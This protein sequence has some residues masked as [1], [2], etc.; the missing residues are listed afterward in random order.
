M[1]QRHPGAGKGDT[2]AN[3]A[4]ELRPNSANSTADRALDVLL[5]F[6]DD[7]PIWSAADL[8]ERLKMPRSTLYRYLNS[9]R[10]YNLIVEDQNGRYRLGP[11]VL[12]LARIAR[13]NTSV[14]QIA[15]PH[16]QRLEAQFGEIVVL[17]ERMGWDIVNLE[18]LPGRH[19]ITLT[20]SRSQ[21]LPWPAAPSA[22][23]FAAFA[24][25]T[26][27]KE[28]QG[29]MRPVA[30]TA[31]TTP[32]L[33]QLKLQLANIRDRGYAVGLEELD[34]GVSGIAVP[35][36]QERRC[37]YSLSLAAPSFRLPGTMLPDVAAVFLTAA[38]VITSELDTL[39]LG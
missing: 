7:V 9:L 19:R 14:L 1:A 5:S 16:M 28:M 38:Q 23:L 17:K 26:E 4:S 8:A 25:P 3:P 30:F 29:L 10:G 22:K 36:F 33:R 24:S 32:N 12:H 39:G 35:V 13:L 20:A 18:T 31:H 6:S 15:L 27:W 21:L 11:R 34:D 37:R 2:A